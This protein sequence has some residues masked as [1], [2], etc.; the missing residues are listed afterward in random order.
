MENQL[1]EQQQQLSTEQQNFLNF[2]MT[3][4]KRKVEALESI[5]RSLDYLKAG[6]DKVTDFQGTTLSVSLY[7]EP[8]D[9]DDQEAIG[10]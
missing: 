5:A 6:F 3:V 2:Q 9:D 7:Q 4:E 10:I 8:D 1:Q